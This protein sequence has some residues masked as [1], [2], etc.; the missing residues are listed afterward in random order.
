M[1]IEIDGMSG[2]QLSDFVVML[3]R[4]DMP[5][6]LM[7]EFDMSMKRVRDASKSVREY[8]RTHGGLSKL[9]DILKPPLPATTNQQITPSSGMERTSAG[10]RD[11]LFDTMASLKRGDILHQDAVAVCK[12]S[13]QIC[14]TVTLEM[15]AENHMAVHDNSNVQT[16]ALKLGG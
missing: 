6:T 8:A 9:I 15:Q 16:K 14:K 3:N 4:G 5:E 7:D 2:E 13:E 11:M 12:I 1:S 10:L